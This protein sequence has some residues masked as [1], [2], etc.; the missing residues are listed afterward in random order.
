MAKRCDEV[1]E[2]NDLKHYQCHKKVHAKPMTRGEFQAWKHNSPSEQ[3]VIDDPEPGYL[4][5]YSM[6]TP[7]EYESWSPK[8]AFEEGYHRNH[9]RSISR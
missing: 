7:D 4:V 3:P 9:R 1:A 6:N 8:Q 2:T 5:I